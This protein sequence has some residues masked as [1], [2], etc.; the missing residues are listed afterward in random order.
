[1]SEA[2]ALMS[3]V[4]VTAFQSV[5]VGAAPMTFPPGGPATPTGAG[6]GGGGPF[7]SSLEPFSSAELVGL[8]S[9][10]KAA[11]RASVAGVRRLGLLQTNTVVL[12]GCRSKMVVPNHCTAVRTLGLL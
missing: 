4:Q 11:L 3:C 9:A 10:T 6:A 2:C 8:D 12:P 1:M 7:A 5:P